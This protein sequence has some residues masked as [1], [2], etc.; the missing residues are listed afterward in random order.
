VFTHSP[1][2]AWIRWLNTWG[3][4]MNRSNCSTVFPF[5]VQGC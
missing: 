5:H 3:K 4:T 2:Y 1:V